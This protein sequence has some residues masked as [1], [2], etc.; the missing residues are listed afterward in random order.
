MINL[1]SKVYGLLVFVWVLIMTI[2]AG[3]SNAAMT[4]ADAGREVTPQGATLLVECTFDTTPGTAVAALPSSTM[5]W[6]KRGYVYNFFTLY[7]ADALCTALDTPFD[8]C[9]AAST[10][11]CD[12]VTDNSDL[13][14]LDAR[15]LTILAA[16]GNG[17]NMADNGA[18]NSV[19]YGDGP[20]PGTDDHSHVGNGS[21]WTLT[22]TNNAVNNSE[23]TLGINVSFER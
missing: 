8:C 15:G 19:F 20:T 6:I 21:A 10:G 13:Q 3:V 7:H 12:G 1:K 4:C 14:I 17:A 9:T 22:V 23:F 11:D 16:A 2:M 5:A 18:N